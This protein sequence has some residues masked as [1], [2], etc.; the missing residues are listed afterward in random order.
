MIRKIINI[1]NILTVVTILTLG[2]TDSYTS[3]IMMQQKGSFAESNP[4]ISYIYIEYGF[5]S[6]I[7]FKIFCTVILI[8]MIYRVQKIYKESMYWKINGTLVSLSMAGILGTIANIRSIENLVLMSPMQFIIIYLIMIV[9][10][11]NIGDYIDRYVENKNE[12]KS[13]GR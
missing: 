7:T 3:A 9:S 6:V 11:I 13:V 5:W 8:L 10:F 12:K 4:I 2:L 1:Q